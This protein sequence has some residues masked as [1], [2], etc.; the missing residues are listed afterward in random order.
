MFETVLG[1]PKNA[2]N[3]LSIK[4]RTAVKAV[5]IQNHKILLM[6]SNRGDFKFPGGGV[7]KGET[8]ESALVREVAEE[9][10]YIHCDVKDPLGV[11]TQRHTDIYEEDTLFEMTSHYFRCELTDS[12]KV[13]QQLEEYE[14]ELEM[15]PEWVSLDD[16]IA[17]N[18][19]LMDQ[20]ENNQ[21]IKR[22]NYVLRELKRLSI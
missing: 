21:W 1:K 11:V 3:K 16:A 10:G 14:S 8:L 6:H 18:E 4:F 13:P 7:E 17:G 15:V 9:T 22:E 19:R 2:K 12:D 20:F 5:I